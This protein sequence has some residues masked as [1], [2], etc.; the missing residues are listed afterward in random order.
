MPI[1]FRR[2]LPSD[3]QDY[4]T[5]RTEMTRLEPHAFL[6][7]PGDDPFGEPAHVRTILDSDDQAIFGAFD[8]VTLIAAAGLFR[9]P[10]AKR[11]HVCGIWGVYTR[12]AHR[13]RGVSRTLIGMC[14]QH[15]ENWRGVTIVQLS[16]S[17][18]ATTAQRLYESLGFVAWGIE[19]DGVQVGNEYV[20]EVHMWRRIGNPH[21]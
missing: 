17:S 9:Q 14:L 11:R 18:R 8:G 1:A 12:A 10:R 5:F 21:S 15:A 3:A 19:P 20:D 2:L 4:A 13:G 16:A 7:T 6:G